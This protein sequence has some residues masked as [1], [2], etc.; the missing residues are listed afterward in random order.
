MRGIKMRAET[1]QELF[2]GASP[3]PSIQIYIEIPTCVS[4][5]HV[6]FSR[7]CTEEYGLS[8]GQSTD[9]SDR[10]VDP[11]GVLVRTNDRLQLPEDPFYMSDF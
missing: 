8:D 5:T 6:P 10:A 3:W 1:C 2:C 9:A 4:I 7:R 11:R